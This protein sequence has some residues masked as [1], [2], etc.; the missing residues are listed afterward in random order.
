MYRMKTAKTNCRHHLIR[1]H[2]ATYDKTVLEKGWHYPLSTEKPGATVTVG[3][4]RKRALPQFTPET[5]LD[6][7][8]RFVVADDQVSN[9]FYF[10]I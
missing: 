1:E 10:S 7:L 2:P 6:Y 8:V 9:P 4:L 5:F 3:E